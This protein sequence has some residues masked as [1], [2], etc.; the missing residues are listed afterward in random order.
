M[1]RMHGA[2][3]ASA[4]FGSNP[5]RPSIDGC[6]ANPYNRIHGIKWWKHRHYKGSASL[7]QCAKTLL[8]S[9]ERMKE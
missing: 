5:F 1:A 2:S 6:D 8:L 7:R 3:H 4:T 9:Y